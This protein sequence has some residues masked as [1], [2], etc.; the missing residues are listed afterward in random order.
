VTFADYS[1]LNVLLAEEDNTSQT[2]GKSE[3]NGRLISGSTVKTV[4]DAI[5]RCQ[6]RNYSFKQVVMLL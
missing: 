5:I 6:E 1:Q 2:L 4:L 3:I